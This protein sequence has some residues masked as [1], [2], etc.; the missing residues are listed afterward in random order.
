M[1]VEAVAL[2]TDSEAQVI[3]NIHIR[4]NMFSL[5]HLNHLPIKFQLDMFV[6]SQ[7]SAATKHQP[8]QPMA[9][10]ETTKN[11]E[12]IQRQTNTQV[13]WNAIIYDFANKISV[14]FSFNLQL[15]TKLRQLRYESV[16]K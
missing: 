2:A 10:A 11:G 3:S 14:F 8:H 1:E 13:L 7:I 6:S 4:Y 12:Q 9:A 15:I 16:L 5:N